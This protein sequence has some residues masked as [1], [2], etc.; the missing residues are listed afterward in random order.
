MPDETS[1]LTLRLHQ[2]LIVLLRQY[3]LVGGMPAAVRA[4]FDRVGSTIGQKVKYLK[5]DAHEQARETRKLFYF[6]IG[7]AG[8]I[9][10]ELQRATCRSFRCKPSIKAE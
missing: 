1:S 7:L 4:F 5:I 6:D 8:P 3:M 10:L 9:P 2:E